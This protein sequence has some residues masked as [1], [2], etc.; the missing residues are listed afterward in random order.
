MLQTILRGDTQMV[1]SELEE[2]VGQEVGV[3]YTVERVGRGGQFR[4]IKFVKVFVVREH[5][6]VQVAEVHHIH[7]QKP[8][9]FLFSQKEGV[10]VRAVGRVLAYTKKGGVRDFTVQEFR[11]ERVVK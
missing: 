2:F 6:L 8:T 3:E 5:K 4:C 10:V 9:E 7:V 1:R 11:A